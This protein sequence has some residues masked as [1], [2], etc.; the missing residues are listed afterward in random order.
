MCGIFGIITKENSLLTEQT[1]RS[2]VNRLFKLSESRGKEAAGLALRS[3]DTI[4][5]IKQP[6]SASKMI[7]TKEYRAIFRNLHLSSAQAII[8][9]S[10]LVTNGTPTIQ[11]N[12]D[13]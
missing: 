9:H 4:K 1:F 6:V 8:G 13:D 11:H 5:I 3:N 12:Q 10:R 2:T 7:R